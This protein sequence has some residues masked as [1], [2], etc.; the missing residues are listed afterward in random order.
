MQNM[1][2]RR[3]VA[4]KGYYDGAGSV[5]IEGGSVRISRL[6]DHHICGVLSWPGL[7]N[8][9]IMIFVGG[10]AVARGAARSIPSDGGLSTELSFDIAW[11]GQPV[12]ETNVLR[13]YANGQEVASFEPAQIRSMLQ[14]LRGG[15]VLFCSP[16]WII[17]Q[18]FSTE[19]HTQPIS[20]TLE[21][22]GRILATGTA[23][24]EEEAVKAP[25]PIK[26]GSSAFRVDIGELDLSSSSGLYQTPVSPTHAGDS[27]IG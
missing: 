19:E 17:C 25:G 7:H 3:R 13:V 12:T 11:R 24:R 10:E 18:V 22:N 6:E 8:A 1:R 21:L 15:K 26:S 14:S 16:D 4:R 20:V 27:R 23:L 5:P 9:T 2:K